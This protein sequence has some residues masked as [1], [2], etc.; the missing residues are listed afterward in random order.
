MSGGYDES[1][2]GQF[3]GRKGPLRNL[4]VLDLSRV[5]SGPYAAMMLGDMGARVIKVERPEAGDDTRSWGPPFVGPPEHRESTYFLSINRNKESITLDFRDESDLEVLKD[6]I[7]RADV[8]IENFRPGVMDRLGLGAE[9]ITELNPALVSVSISGFGQNGPDAGRSGYDQIVQGEAGIMSMTGTDEA[10]PVKVGIPIGDV[11]AG[12]LA[13]VGALTALNERSI[14]G[15]GTAVGT[16]LLSALVSTH[17]FQGTRWL[18]GGD[19]PTPSGNQHPTVAPYGAFSCSDGLIQIAVG[20]DSLWGKFAVLIGIEPG[21]SRFLTNRDRVENRE[22]LH[23]LLA[24]AFER[25]T[26]D[27]WMAALN[28]SGIPAGRIRS[29][30][31][32]YADPQV[33]SQ[34]LI[35]ELDH[36]TLGKIKVPGSGVALTSPDGAYEVQNRPP[37]LLGEHSQQVRNWLAAGVSASGANNE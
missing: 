3:D 4:L 27:T 23:A 13:V 17:V 7:R 6:L 21:D 15:R 36:P 34:G 8:L 32:V 26:V 2:P 20:N 35:L 29:L 31:E 14:T 5:L 11:M 1:E 12:I 16:S 30:D 37:P 24:R 9:S 33:E 18:I 19:L 22:V 10:H 28:S 25:E